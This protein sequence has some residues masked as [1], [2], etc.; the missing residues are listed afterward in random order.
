MT[1]STADSD[2]IAGFA[3]RIQGYRLTRR[4]LVEAGIKAG[5]GIAA[6]QFLLAGCGSG[7]GSA[8][9]LGKP[10]AG[11]PSG[12]LTKLE[13]EVDFFGWTYEPD[14][15]QKNL[16]RWSDHFKVK[17]NYQNFPGNQW[18]QKM[19]TLFQAGTN[20][21][22][23]YVRDDDLAAWVDAGYLRPL[24]GFPG[25]DKL[26]PEMRKANHDALMYNG[27]TYCLP[28]YT[29]PEGF[30]YNAQHL[31]K[32]GFSNP[33]RTLD[34]LRDQAQKLRKDKI[35]EYPLLFDWKASEL[36]G[37]EFWN[38]VYG[39]G[40]S[41]FDQNNDPVFPDKDDTIVKV[42]QWVRDGIAKWEIID[43]KSFESENS[44]I[45]MQ[46]GQSTYMVTSAYVMW[47]F[48]DP[49][50]SKVAGQVKLAPI[51][52]LKAGDKQGNLFSTRLYGVGTKAKHPNAAYQLIYY[53]GGQ[54]WDNNFFTAKNWFLQRGLG[55]P[56]TPLDKDKE[57]IDFASTWIDLGM[58]SKLL[59]SGRTRQAQNTPWY[60]E[61]WRFNQL[62][63]ME[64]VRGSKPPEQAMKESADKARELKKQFS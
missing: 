28:Y 55:A 27:K 1:V 48:N 19:V 22:A 13:S 30:A 57:V 34:E 12:T 39:S 6:L 16:D 35:V 49:T 58:F 17:V 47:L 53:M 26:F 44:S 59:E 50:K 41:L 61:W 46:Q 2:R 23:L 29:T 32:A 63:L 4:E 14:I 20:I 64:A 52:S 9:A 40:G 51:P 54:D 62:R 25:L 42:L 15:V 45:A 60:T 24:D 56:Y 7:S 43:P 11:A 21:D 31:Q 3:E 38:L 5:V 10:P 36:M 37:G 18:H 33:P 8:A